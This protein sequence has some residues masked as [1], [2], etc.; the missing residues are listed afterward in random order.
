MRRTKNE[1]RSMED[2]SG[3]MRRSIEVVAW[4]GA[5]KRWHGE[6]HENGGMR[7]SMEAAA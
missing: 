2:R 3:G 5:W 1:R 7:R 4:R 6:E